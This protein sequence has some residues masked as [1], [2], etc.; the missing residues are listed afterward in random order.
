MIYI[1]LSLFT[2]LNMIFSR[3]STLLQMAKNFIIFYGWVIYVSYRCLC[4]CIIYKHILKPIVCWWTLWL[5][6]CLGYCIRW[7]NG[8]HPSDSS[9]HIHKKKRVGTV[10][11]KVTHKISCLT[12]NKTTRVCLLL[13]HY[14][15]KTKACHFSYQSCQ[16]ITS[17]SRSVIHSFPLFQDIFIMSLTTQEW[18][19]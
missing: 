12:N 1:C 7:L 8:K 10:Q 4:V 15:L 13:K 19:R 9:P 11:K 5:S 16:Y 6:P 18:T 17:T 14:P 3:S 2:S